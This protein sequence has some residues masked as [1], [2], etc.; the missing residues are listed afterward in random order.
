MTPSRS[1]PHGD[2]VLRGAA[3]HRLGVVAD[4]DQGAGVGGHRDD[5]GLGEDDP[6]AADVDQRWWPCPGRSRGRARRTGA[7]SGRAI[8]LT[9]RFV[10][11]VRG[12][13][14]RVNGSADRS[15]IP[16]TPT[17]GQARPGK[18][19]ATSRAADSGESEP[20]VTF[21]LHDAWPGRRGSFPGRRSRGWW[22]PSSSRHWTIA[23]GPSTTAA[24]SGPRGDEVHEVGEERLGDV[25]AV[26]R[27]GS[28]PVQGPQLEG[29][30]AQAL[31]LDARRAPRRSGCAPRR[32]A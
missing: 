32:R 3:Q 18:N 4:P 19:S 28:G 10:R 2:D 1:G 31:A 25:L 13:G 7:A 24:T 9:P 27:L 21:S 12:S 11:S 26:V 23:S 22:R 14:H 29:H 17:S 20:C 6:G 5:R 8:A 16:Y 15:S 30:D